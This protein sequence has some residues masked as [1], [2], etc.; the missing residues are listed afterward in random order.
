M[1]LLSSPIDYVPIAMM[2]VVAIGFVLVTMLA[3]HLLGPKRN[4]KVKLETFEC[5]IEPQGNSRLPFSIKYFLIAILFVLFDVE[6]IFF[7]PYA[8]NFRALGWDGFIAVAMF[9]GF[10]IVGFTYIIKKNALQWED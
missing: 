6:V 4:S 10:F 2:F 7:Y 5:G 9:I 8:V 1:I 3:T